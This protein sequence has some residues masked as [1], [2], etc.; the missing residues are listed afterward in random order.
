MYNLAQSLVPVRPV[1]SRPRPSSLRRVL[2][3]IV[4][5]LLLYPLVSGAPAASAQAQT[6]MALSAGAVH[7]CAL[8]SNATVMC[9]G[10]NSAG[11]LGD[12]TTTDRLTPTTVPN[13]SNVTALSAGA[14]HTCALL[15]DGTMRCWGA[16]DRA[17]LGNQRTTNSSTPVTVTRPAIGVFP[18]PA[19]GTV[20]AISA[21]GSHTCA[22]INPGSV[23]CWGANDFGQ[24]SP[25]GLSNVDVPVAVPGVPTDM[26]SV[27]AGGAHSCAIQ[28]TNVMYCWGRNNRGQLGR[29]TTDATAVRNPAVL[30]R[31]AGGAVSPS[32]T[33]VSAGDEHTCAITDRAFRNFTLMCWGS[34][35]HGQI[36]DG[37]TTN[38]PFPTAVATFAADTVDAVSASG[39]H[40]CAV[41]KD[42]SVRC[43]GRNLS[44]ELGD[45]STTNRATPVLIALAGPQAVR[46]VASGSFHSCAVR[47]D[48]RVLCWG[49]GQSGQLGR[50]STATSTTPDAVRFPAGV[51]GVPSV[52]GPEVTAEAGVAFEYATGWDVTEPLV[53]RDLDQALLIFTDTSAGPVDGEDE[54]APA[55][56]ITFQERGGTGSSL[57]AVDSTLVSLN[58][59]ASRIEGSGPD[60]RTVRLFLNLTFAPGAAGK[61]FALS[62]VVVAD[63]GSMQSAEALGVI[64]V[65]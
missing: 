3:S 21:G 56:T 44:G 19:L 4:A 43:W 59:N 49:R 38:R 37:T 62:I 54:P 9:W 42:A 23:F 18:T 47:T 27:S 58:T 2:L 33:K 14:N 61:T 46:S 35:S 36:G 29:G 50:G 64:T 52:G 48:E 5:V 31:E 63:D 65:Q 30:V 39:F 41:G 53:W 20:L 32:F 17:Q 12:G 8:M 6:V 55:F 40:S 60:G 57:E 24:S 25:G 1:P 13:L 26:T 45:G 22:V 51:V 11:Q 16:N 15:R 28:R 10:G 7:T 34:N